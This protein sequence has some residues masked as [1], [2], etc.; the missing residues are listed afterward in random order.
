[1]REAA[2]GLAF[3][4]GRG[5]ID[6]WGGRIIGR[7]HDIGDVA[8]EVV[9][10]LLDELNA[11][12][13][14]L[15]HDFAAVIGGVEYTVGGWG[16]YEVNRRRAAWEA[17]GGAA[18][19]DPACRP[20]AQYKGRTNI[21]AADAVQSV[22]GT[23]HGRSTLR[24]AALRLAGALA[25]LEERLHSDW[26]NEAQFLTIPPM[27]SDHLLEFANDP[28]LEK[29]P[30]ALRE[31]GADILATAA[32][33]GIDLP[34]LPRLRESQL[35]SHTVNA[36]DDEEV[37]RLEEMVVPHISE[38]ESLQAALAAQLDKVASHILEDTAVGPAGE[39]AD[40]AGEDMD[41]AGE[42]ADAA[43]EDMDAAS[44]DKD[45]KKNAVSGMRNVLRDAIR[46]VVRGDAPHPGD[47][48]RSS[49][50]VTRGAEVDAA[51]QAAPLELLEVGLS[52]HEGPRAFDLREPTR[53]EPTG[54][55]D[56]I[57]F[58]IA[59]RSS[60]ARSTLLTPETVA[61]AAFKT[62]A[63]MYAWFVLESPEGC[64][65]LRA[66][67]QK[68]RAVK[69]DPDAIVAWLRTRLAGDPPHKI[70]IAEYVAH[71]RSL[72]LAEAPLAG[73]WL[74]FLRALAPGSVRGVLHIQPSVA[75]LDALDSLF[76][77]AAPP[78]LAFA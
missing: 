31:L 28:A 37:L 8:G 39:D 23:R 14:D 19:A 67:P 3:Q 56:G 29:N 72:G 17:R 47:V 7:G 77:P 36:S 60:A 20:G 75:M 35:P 4:E 38:L 44:E 55:H 24:R 15:D 62:S 40:A 42:D 33:V 51:A 59:G 1:V 9:A 12:G 34:P 70:A 64:Y 45:V 61:T 52:W 65:A 57:Y 30:V 2:A 63:R 46:E 10:E 26:S 54:P 68:D 58:G 13:G 18:R 27:T 43:G 6:F 22:M 74:V 16:E 69:L 48:K 5:F 25:G 53:A 76:A 66:D 41:A 50:D 78:E 49:A 11:F 71:L 73:A 32:A 21:H